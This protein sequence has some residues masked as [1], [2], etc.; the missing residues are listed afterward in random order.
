M[1]RFVSLDNYLLGEDES[2]DGSSTCT[3]TGDC[4]H[5]D[6]ERDSRVKDVITCESRSEHNFTDF[7]SDVISEEGITAPSRIASKAGL[8]CFSS[9]ASSCSSV[10][11]GSHNL[12]CLSLCAEE[13]SRY[14]DQFV[15]SGQWAD[16]GHNNEAFEDVARDGSTPPSEM[17]T[18]NANDVKL[19]FHDISL[20]ESSDSAIGVSFTNSLQSGTWNSMKDAQHTFPHGK[21]VLS[22]HEPRLR[23]DSQSIQID[24]S[25]SDDSCLP[26][27]SDGSKQPSVFG[28]DVI[29]RAI[30]ILRRNSSVDIH[31]GHNVS[32]I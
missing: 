4:V 30:K 26:G 27:S 15:D 3:S 20:Y 22:E 32:N 8:K 25:D 6:R 28:A 19:D 21:C 17:A 16:V 1:E 2:I 5:T 14:D 18:M 10:S 23:H 29:N 12:D 13:M 24:D 7:G 9:A 31:Q 11:G